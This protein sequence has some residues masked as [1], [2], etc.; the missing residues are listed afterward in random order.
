MPLKMSLFQDQNILILI[1]VGGVE[2]ME[3]SYSSFTV[4]R[5]KIQKGRWEDHFPNEK[6]KLD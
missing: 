2:F 5:V 3:L 1:L 6:V 4:Q